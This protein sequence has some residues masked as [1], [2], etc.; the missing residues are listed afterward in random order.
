MEWKEYMTDLWGEIKY[1]QV[2]LGEKGDKKRLPE[3]Y[4]RLSQQ[5]FREDRKLL[6]FLRTSELPIKTL[7][8]DKP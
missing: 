7:M 5:V 1:V 3:E 2:R 6:T 8:I 4:L